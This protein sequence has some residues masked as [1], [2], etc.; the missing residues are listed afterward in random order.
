MS[1]S[2]LWDDCKSTEEQRARVFRRW[3]SDPDGIYNERWNNLRLVQLAIMF[4]V[5]PL[6]RK[7]SN[8]L[9]DGYWCDGVGYLECSNRLITD[10]QFSGV[11]VICERQARRGLEPFELDIQYE[12]D[13]ANIPANLALRLGERAGDKP[14]ALA[15]PEGPCNLQASTDIY[16]GRPNFDLGWA[17][18]L[19]FE[20]YV[21]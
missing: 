18:S 12:S 2:V 7:S 11:L 5:G 15:T 13:S 6:L 17:V 3:L 20:P 4:W 10:L 16:S 1:N 8:T 19:S 14:F 9:F 21:A